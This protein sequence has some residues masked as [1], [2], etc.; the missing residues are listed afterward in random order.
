MDLMEESHRNKKKQNPRPTTK[1]Y[2]ICLALCKK[3]PKKYF[4]LPNK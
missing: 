4:F 3:L 1:N 2:D